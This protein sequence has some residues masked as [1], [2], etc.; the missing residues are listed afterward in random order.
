MT[1]DKYRDDTTEAVDEALDEA[2][3]PERPE[4]TETTEAIDEDAQSEDVEAGDEPVEDDDKQLRQWIAEAMH[5]ALQRRLAKRGQGPQEQ[6]GTTRCAT[7]ILIRRA[8]RCC[9]CAAWFCYPVRA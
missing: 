4:E 6:E 3:E 9:R 1:D 7:S 2:L 5:S 8:T